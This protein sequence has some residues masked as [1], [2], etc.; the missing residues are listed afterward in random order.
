MICPECKNKIGQLKKYQIYE[1]RCGAKLMCI[2]I[3]K[4]KEIVNLSKGED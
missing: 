1:C 3:N 4:R 2:E